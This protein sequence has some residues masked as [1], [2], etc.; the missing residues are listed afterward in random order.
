M[1]VITR[2]VSISNEL[3]E[4]L[5]KKEL[6]EEFV[7]ESKTINNWR[8]TDSIVITQVSAGF[9]WRM[10]KRG[11]AFWMGIHTEYE[12]RQQEGKS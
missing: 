9:E 3:S 5:K 6:L 1:T 4:F 8:G 11:Q 12:L 7:E 2:K 10:S